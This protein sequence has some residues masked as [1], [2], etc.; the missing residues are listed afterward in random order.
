MAER[1]L[2]T[3][4]LWSPTESA[5]GD[6]HFRW[7]QGRRLSQ[8]PLTGSTHGLPGARGATLMSSC[9]DP[10]RHAGG[11]WARVDHRRHSLEGKGRKSHWM[12]KPGVEGREAVV[13]SGGTT[14]AGKA[15]LSGEDGRR[16]RGRAP[17][18]PL[19]FYRVNVSVLGTV[20]SPPF[21]RHLQKLDI[22][23]RILS[24]RI[25]PKGLRSLTGTLSLKLREELWV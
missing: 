20:V 13:Q 24:L 5:P 1:S 10:G 9:S 11:T 18:T 4:L 23:T 19:G 21:Q 14:T 25:K 15:W 8:A 16:A 17:A 7:N 12:G 2:P 6:G 22:T 3:A